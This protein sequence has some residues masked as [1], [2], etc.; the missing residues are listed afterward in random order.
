[1]LLLK[2]DDLTWSR[3]SWGR[4]GPVTR[5][6]RPRVVAE[7]GKPRVIVRDEATASL[8]LQSETE[9]E[10]A[11]DLLLPG[12]TAIPLAHRLSTAMKRDRIVVIEAG[13]V[14][15][16]CAPTEPISS[17][18]RFAAMYATWTEHATES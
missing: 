4:A 11:L 5:T 7:P 13:R 9:V 15:E 1:M 6:T 16:F 18:G 12:R 14:V 17:G 3:P 2:H 8:D 10:Q